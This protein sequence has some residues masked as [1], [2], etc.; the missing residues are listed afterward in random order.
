MKAKVDQTRRGNVE[1]LLSDLRLVVVLPMAL[2]LALTM[3]EAE[4]AEVERHTRRAS[5]NRNRLPYS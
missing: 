2:L 1:I 3:C 5:R 4:V